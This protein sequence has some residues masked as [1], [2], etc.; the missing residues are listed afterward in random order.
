M[1]LSLRFCSEKVVLLQ[2]TK[3]ISSII[4]KGPQDKTN[5]VNNL[6]TS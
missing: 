3:E 4:I 1:F 6:I 2:H 5:N